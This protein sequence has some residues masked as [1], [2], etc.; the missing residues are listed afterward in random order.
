MTAGSGLRGSPL[1]QLAARASRPSRWW[2]AWLV[3]LLII[4]LVTPLGTFIGRIVAVLLMIAIP[5]AAGIPG[6]RF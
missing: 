2:L 5:F 3:A 4:H 6:P 1:V